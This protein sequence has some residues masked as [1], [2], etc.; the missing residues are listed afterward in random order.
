MRGVA[1]VLAPPEHPSTEDL[2]GDPLPWTGSLGSG[3]PLF[4]SG[5]LR[6]QATAMQVGW[7]VTRI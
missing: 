1:G 2:A 3:G 5:L 4:Y 6:W 7:L